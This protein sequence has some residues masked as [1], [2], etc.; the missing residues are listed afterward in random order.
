MID[1]VLN[2]LEWLRKIP[3][4]FLLALSV[5][6]ALLLFLPI[7]IAE[8]LAVKEFR[9][10]YR[11]FLGPSFLVVVSFFITKA[12]LSVNNIRRIKVNK[13]K[14]LLQLHSLTAEEKGYLAQFMKCGD[15]TI[16]VA[17]GDG[18]AGG[19]EA[20]GIIYRSSN[21][22]NILEGLPYNLQPW[23]Q[24]YLCKRLSLLDGAV[25]APQTNMERIFGRKT[26]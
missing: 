1:N 15:N 11:K 14:R 3:A 9:D 19:L 5:V 10:S 4:G 23:A 25:G 12:L 18:V 22:F 21:S 6:L 16:H 24:D 13:S 26:W 17:M 7:E 2:I 8:T 20:K